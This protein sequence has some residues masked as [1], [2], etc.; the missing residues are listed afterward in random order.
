[1]T[2]AQTN[3]ALDDDT[4][5]IKK[6]QCRT[7]QTNRSYKMSPCFP[8]FSGKCRKQNTWLTVSRLDLNLHCDSGNMYAAK[9]E[10]DR[11]KITLTTIL[12]ANDRSLI[13]L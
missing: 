11:F 2:N 13:K 6:T 7:T 9:E 5:G 10:L 12:P 4:K 3:E 1:M 8:N